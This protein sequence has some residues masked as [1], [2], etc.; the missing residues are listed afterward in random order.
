MGIIHFV[1]IIF[2]QQLCSR[3]PILKCNIFRII[4]IFLKNVQKKQ[5]DIRNKIK[6]KNRNIILLTICDYWSAFSLCVWQSPFVVTLVWYCFAFIIIV[7]RFGEQMP[8]LADW[9]V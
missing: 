3:L 5:Y 6:G 4:P 9:R 7:A 1:Q 2:C 8:V